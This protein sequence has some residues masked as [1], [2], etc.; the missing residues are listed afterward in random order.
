MLQRQPETLLDADRNA[1]LEETT[2]K[3][4]CTLMSPYQNA[5][6]NLNVNIAN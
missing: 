3:I 2:Q 4:K 1:S 6:Q 5:G